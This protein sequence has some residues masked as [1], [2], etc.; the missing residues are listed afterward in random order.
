MK[1]P[2]RSFSLKAFAIALAISGVMSGLLAWFL[3]M[4]FLYAFLI[5]LCAI[6]ING[7]IA[8]I[9]DRSSEETEK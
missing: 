2:I 9:N 7:W 1:S 3:G 5:V 4:N 8:G 6:L